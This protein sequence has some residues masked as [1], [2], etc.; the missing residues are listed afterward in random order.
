MSHNFIHRRG[1][2]E[3]KDATGHAHDGALER[4]IIEIFR[5]LGVASVLDLGCGLGVYAAALRQ[6]G[7]DCDAY[8]GNPN[9]EIL[10]NGVGHPLDLSVAI[11]LQKRYD[12]VLSLEVGEHIPAEF[13]QVFIDN[14]CRHARR[15]VLLSWAVEGQPGTGHVNCRSN[16]YVAAAMQRS[17]FDVVPE[18]SMVL[19]RQSSLWWFG[20]TLMWFQRQSTAHVHGG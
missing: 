9:T 4:S 19:R 16:E 14:I 5:R 18:H 13:E 3:T 2:W 10:T 7:F 6:E 15:H 11:D 20:N 8:D 12:C 17:G 1:Y